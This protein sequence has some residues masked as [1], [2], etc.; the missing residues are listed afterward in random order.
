[1]HSTAKLLPS[2]ISKWFH[3]F[4]RIHVLFYNSQK[5]ER[6]EK[7]QCFSWI[8]LQSCYRQPIFTISMF[9][10]KK[11][12][13]FILKTLKFELFGDC[14]IF[15]RFYGRSAAFAILKVFSFSGK[16]EVFFNFFKSQKLN[17][18]R[19]LTNSIELYSK[20]V[21]I[22]DFWKI[23]GFFRKSHLFCKKPNFWTFWEISLFRSHLTSNWLTVS[24][25]V[26][27]KLAKL[28]CF[29]K[30]GFLFWKNHLF[31]RTQFF[32]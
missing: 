22:S 30:F 15:S 24:L 27:I 4:S 32:E 19:N 12:V 17:V 3:F 1:M 21:T 18:L 11:S 29:Q 8:L 20:F 14:Y 9:L 31:F 2:V 13:F 28:S 16:T 7:C 6:F 26:D 23:Q 25:A 5:F 10:F